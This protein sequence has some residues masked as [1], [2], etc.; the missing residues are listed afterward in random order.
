MKETKLELDRLVFFSD[1]VV[2]IAITLL[3]LDLKVDTSVNGHLTFIDLGNSWPKFNGFFLSFII[4][5]LFWRKHHNFFSHIKNIDSKLIKMNIRWLLFIVLLPFSS[6]LITSHLLD[7]PAIL[8]YCLNVLF[9]TLFQNRIWVYVTTKQG[10]L[11]ENTSQA[12]IDDNRLYCTVAMINALIATAISF[13]SPIAA[14]I[15]LFARI[16]M[17]FVAKKLLSQEYY[18]NN[19]K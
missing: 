12:E 10:F 6:S 2:A 7:Q 18:E 5:A 11:K 15:I 1:A 8:F 19:I 14:F 13:L 16:P 17:L 3:A 9:L 4:I